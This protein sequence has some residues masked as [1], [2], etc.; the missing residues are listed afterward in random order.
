MLQQR[1]KCGVATWAYSAM[2]SYIRTAWIVHVTFNTCTVV[3]LVGSHS[4]ASVIYISGHVAVNSSL[5][6]NT[7]NK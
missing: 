5:P 4:D 7:E 6:M 1:A 3:W 2:S